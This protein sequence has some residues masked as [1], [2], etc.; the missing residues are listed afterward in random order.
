M[1]NN[2][3]IINSEKDEVSVKNSILYKIDEER[4]GVER[5]KKKTIERDDLIMFNFLE[6]VND[7]E[8]LLENVI[9]LLMP[10]FF[11]EK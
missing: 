11:H 5:S 6:Y 10:S 8:N 2:L 1:Q 3:M 4:D 9:L 7:A